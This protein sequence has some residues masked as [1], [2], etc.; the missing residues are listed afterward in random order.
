[1]PQVT[2][3]ISG[4]QYRMACADGEEPHLESLAAHL[5][6]KI[7]EMRASFGEIGDMRLQVMAALMISDELSEAQKRIAGLEQQ[8]AGL[9]SIALA[10][11]ERSNALESRITGDIL[12]AADRIERLA[13]SLNTSAAGNA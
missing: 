6:R 8:L 7:E 11:D 3:T 5:D 12:R 4:R 9:Q 2:V 1:M 10:G 13:R